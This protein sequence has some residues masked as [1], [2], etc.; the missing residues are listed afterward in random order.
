[1]W[2]RSWATGRRGLVQLAS[3]FGPRVLH[4]YGFFFHVTVTRAWGHTLLTLLGGG[5][6]VF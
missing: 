6:A 3:T 4:L 5:S 1:M 2:C